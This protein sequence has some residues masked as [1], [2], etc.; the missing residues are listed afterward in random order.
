[1]Y[2]MLTLIFIS[3]ICLPSAYGELITLSQNF[4]V[5][6]LLELCCACSMRDSFIYE[7]RNVKC[8]LFPYLITVR[9]SPY[10]RKEHYKTFQPFFQ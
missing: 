5:K 4:M 6:L 10:I 1:M 2:I 9:T 3:H 8:L 7:L